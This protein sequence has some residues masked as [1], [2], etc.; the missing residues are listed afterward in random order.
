MVTT[1]TTLL[2]SSCRQSPNSIQVLSQVFLV[3][4][5]E[6]LSYLTN[7]LAENKDNYTDKHECPSYTSTNVK[8]A[9]ITNG[10]HKCD[11][12]I[13]DS[14]PDESTTRADQNQSGADTLGVPIGFS[15]VIC[16]DGS[17]ILL[18]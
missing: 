10:I 12:T 13:R 6:T 7:L 5:S 15:E 8:A 9:F 3:V 18:V 14:K 1:I 16:Q 17:V 11:N 2:S 4:H